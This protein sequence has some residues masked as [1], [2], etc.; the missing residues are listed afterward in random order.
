M[1][2]KLGYRQISILEFGVA[3]GNGLIY[4][5]YITQKISKLLAI[6]I[7]IYG[8]DTGNGLTEPSDYRDLPYIWEKGFYKMDV[9][10]L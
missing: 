2:K 4:P 7:D 5:E 8:F 1:A 9:P 3:G 10:K 6:D